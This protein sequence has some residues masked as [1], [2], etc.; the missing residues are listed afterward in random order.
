MEEAMLV[1][2]LLLLPILFF[3]AFRVKAGKSGDLRPLPGMDELSSLVE[4]AA[5]TSQ[6]IHVSVGVAG[7]SSVY[8]A[9]TWSG[10]TVLRQLADEAAAYDAPLLVTV[11]DATVLPIAQDMLWQAYSRHGNPERYDSTSVRL[12]A[13]E[14]TAYAA[15]T[16]GLLER[17]P[18]TANIMIGSFG[19][20][21]LLMGEVGARRGVHQVVGAAD[22]QTLPLVYISADEALLGE[23]MFAGGAYT[24]RL[25]IQ[26]GSLFVEDWARWIVIAAVVIT[27]VLRLLG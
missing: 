27:A 9:Q 13:P 8:T 4:R 23:E 26:I 22:P 15:G 25:P 5:E 20:E 19:D 14:P 17:E 3:A 7:V 21:Y 1:L 24:S 16:M 18:L 10:L 2:L 11:S 12:I 6:P